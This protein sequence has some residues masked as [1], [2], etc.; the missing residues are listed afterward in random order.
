[1]RP[2]GSAACSGLIRK[3]STPK[4]RN[5]RSHSERQGITTKQVPPFRAMK[6]IVLITGGQRSGKSSYAEQM[7]LSWSANPVYM[8]TARVWDYF[9][10]I[11]SARR[12]VWIGARRGICPQP[13][14]DTA[15]HRS[16]KLHTRLFSSFRWLE[17]PLHSPKGP[18]RK[19]CPFLREITP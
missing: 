17:A 11:A 7:A 9:Q 10:M 3:K 2:A 15:C 12:R 19:L 6:R 5:L 8:A 13:G 16:P 14:R 18:P 1:M 4:P